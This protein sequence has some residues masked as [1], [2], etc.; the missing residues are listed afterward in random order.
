MRAGLAFA[1]HGRAFPISGISAVAPILFTNSE[2]LKTPNADRETD[3]SQ[4]RRTHMREVV[5]AP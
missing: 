5:E 3:S 2:A 4:A 1:V